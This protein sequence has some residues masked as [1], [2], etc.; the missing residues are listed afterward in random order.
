MKELKAEQ[1]NDIYNLFNKKWAL[2][3]AEKDGKVNTMTVSWGQTGI[4]WNKCV[5]TVYVRPSRYTKEFIEYA[6]AFS[7]SFLNE[8]Y[9]KE[10]AY[11][12]KVSG[13]DEDK[14][15]KSGLTV[16]HHDIT[17]YFS[18]A[19]EVFICKTLYKQDMLENSFLDE[20]MKNAMYPEKDWHTQY[21]GEIL[22][23]LKS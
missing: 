13:R 6:D 7:L 5:A 18:E 2:L 15:G 8:K 4:L 1:F 10:L 12:G 23:I 3:T 11:L 9:R 16:V 20:K 22:T 21:I 14:I 19:E 17:P